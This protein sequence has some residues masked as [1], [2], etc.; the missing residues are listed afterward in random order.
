[1]K[2]VE[3]ENSAGRTARILG[4]LQ[5]VGG[6]EISG[7]QKAVVAA[8]VLGRGG[9]QSVVSAFINFYP[10]SF[11]NDDGGLGLPETP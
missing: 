2:V 10:A 1:V 5:L 7:R 4:L 9:N 8:R 6:K 11:S 3:R